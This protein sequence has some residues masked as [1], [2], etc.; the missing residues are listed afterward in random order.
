M[1][2]QNEALAEQL[3][4]VGAERDRMR[5]EVERLRDQ[6]TTAPPVPVPAAAGELGKVREGLLRVSFGEDVTAE[7]IGLPPTE[8]RVFRLI[9]ALL[10][11]AL[12]YELGLNLLLAEFKIGPAGDADTQLTQGL[13]EQVRERFRACLENKEGSLQE[14]SA[15]LERNARFLI[16]LNR[17]YQASIFE[18]NRTMLDRLD[19]R[20]ILESHK[21]VLGSDFEGAW[22]SISRV[23]AD[24]SNLSRAEMWEQFFMKPFQ[25]K[26]GDYQ[27]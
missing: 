7:S 21:R 6:P 27:D 10:N 19:P 24:L 13:Q 3:R 22:K 11:F 5:E 12:K 9:R 17:S 20:P 25:E 15:T 14:L 23:Q 16:D 1:E 26:L 8:A 18:G 4:A 2:R